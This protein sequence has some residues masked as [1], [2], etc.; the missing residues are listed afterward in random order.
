MKTRLSFTFAFLFSCLALSGQNNNGGLLLRDGWLIQ[1]SAQV[2]DK[3]PAVSDVMYNP[4]GWYPT[5]VPSTVFGTLVGNKVY[6]DPYFG[7]NIESVPGYTK[8]RD[9]KM[10]A[11]SPYSVPWWYRTV[12]SLPKN[13]KGQNIFIDFHSINYQAN[14]WLNGQLVADTNQVEGAYRLYNL[15]ITKY[16]RPGEKNCLA[17]EIFPPKGND[18][19]ITWVDWNPT[20]PDRGMGIWYDVKVH[21]TGPVS[22]DNTHIIT[23]LNLPSTDIARLTV[24]TELSNVSSMKVSGTLHG[25][26]GNISFSK[27]V[28]L[29]PGEIVP[30]TFSPDEFRQLEIKNPLL[31]WPYTVGPQNLYDL[32]LSFD[33]GKKGSDVDKIRFGI[34]EVTSWMNNFDKKHTRVFQINGKNIVIRGG[35]YVEDMM[36]RPSDKRVDADLQYLK[37]MGLNALRMEAPRGSDYLFQKCDEEG[38]LLMVGW[39]CCSAW[40]R[41]KTWTPHVADIAELSLKDQVIHLRNKPSVFDWL[42]GSDNFPPADVEKRYIKVLQDYDG[43]RPYQSSA[44]K[45]SSAIAG[46]TGLYMGPYPKVYAYEPPSYWYGKLEFNTEAGP[47]GEQIPPVETLR[48]MMPEKDLW[49]ISDSWNIRLH[50]AFYPEARKALE[51][52]Y[53]KP[54]NVEEYSMKS[55]VLQYEATRAMFE[56]FAGNKYK[57]SGIIYWMYNSAWPSMYWQLYDYFLAP[58]GS[59]YGTRK[60]CEGLHVQYAYDDGS[61]Q[62]VNSQY[63]DF[64]DLKVTAKLYNADMKEIYS[65]EVTTSIK[66]DESKKVMKNEWPENKGEIFFLKLTLSGADGKLISSNFYWL[67]AKGDEKADFTLL[68][69]LPEINLNYKVTDQRKEGGKYSIQVEFENSTNSLAFAVNPKIMRGK[70]GELALPVFWSDNYFS[71]LPGEKQTVSVSLSEEDL[72][73]QPPVL[74]IDGWNIEHTD[75]ELK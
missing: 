42:Y 57:S 23:K 15:N 13:M 74:A 28:N 47:S 8:E 50:K 58:N 68:N 30:V 70:T 41:W 21:A 67:S 18:L 33:T 29:S 53:G 72:N 51:S 43:T 2:K 36:L 66:P 5:S 25:T 64:P 19:T 46:Y 71:L 3:G 48:M 32:V 31:W 16:A 60:A 11:D 35:G 61:I 63:K 10:P 27:D 9:R 6:P 40:E 69:K 14:I 22:I 26:I 12:F 44:T 52:R 73:G 65:K 56:A 38:I 49:P 54:A 20:P 39:C 34:R 17:L 37:H 24:S 59:F 55:Q 4:Q 7:T 1:S 45:D 75:K 62:V